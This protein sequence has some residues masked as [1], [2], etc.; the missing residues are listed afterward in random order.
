MPTRRS[1][2]RPPD[3]DDARV[4]GILDDIGGVFQD[5]G[6]YIYDHGDQI[7]DIAEVVV[8]MV[9]PYLA[10]AV[11]AEHAI[12][13]GIELNQAQAKAATKGLTA[14]GNAVVAQQQQQAAAAGEPDPAAAA[15]PA[16][17]TSGGAR[18]ELA[19]NRG[20]R[21]KPAESPNR[22]LIL[23]GLGLLAWLLL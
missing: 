6:K 14:V 13:K 16:P 12:R 17:E 20:N 21:G 3:A 11:A 1:I 18:L 7:A 5:G 8:P 4:G 2:P 10:P 19:V 9:A 15:A 23:A 22:G